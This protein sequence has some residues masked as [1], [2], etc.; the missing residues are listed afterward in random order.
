MGPLF[1]QTLQFVHPRL[2]I[3]FFFMLLRNMPPILCIPCKHPTISSYTHPS[4]HIFF[5][6]GSKLLRLVLNS[7][8]SQIRP[9][10]CDLP[11]STSQII[12][13]THIKQYVLLGLMLMFNKT[14]LIFRLGAFISTLFFFVCMVIQDSPLYAVNMLY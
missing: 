2:L 8:C 9:Q 4:F 1:A 11:A 10:T 14:A 6:K 13:Y 7:L 5:E 12:L 3:F